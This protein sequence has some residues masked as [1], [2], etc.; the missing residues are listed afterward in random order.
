MKRFWILI[1]LSLSVPIWGIDL[2][3]PNLQVVGYAKVELPSDLV[4]LSAG[5]VTNAD[6]AEDALS[7]NSLRMQKV[8]MALKESGLKEGE[9]Q[10]SQFNITPTYTPYPNP[11]PPH[12]K[13][14]INGYEVSNTIQIKTDK[15]QDIGAI[16]DTLTKAGANTIHS[17]SFTLKNLEE[18]KT[19]A[20][21]KATE[22]A[23]QKAA[24]LAKSA[25]V[26][27]KEIQTLI[28]D[29]SDTPQPRAYLASA[30][31]SLTPI[32]EGD[33]TITQKVAITFEI[34]PL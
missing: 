19:S 3:N 13:Q 32:V 25:H 24:L 10:T 7:Q 11:L 34:E 18:A 27:L 33:V 8:L 2:P 6:S 29:P 9:Y 20:I 22:D 1:L 30:N 5:V 26:K 12:W 4:I 28:L 14:S 15:I 21:Q 17:I 31:A 16:I 23:L